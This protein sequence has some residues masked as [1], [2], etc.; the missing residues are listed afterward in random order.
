MTLNIPFNRPSKDLLNFTNDEIH[1][2]LNHSAG[3]GKFTK[4]AE[5]L[6]QNFH[7]GNS[8]LLTTSCTSALELTSILLNLNHGDEIIVPSFTF[9]STANA[10]ALRGIK[11]VFADVELGSLNLQ[12]DSVKSCLTEKTKAIVVVNYNGINEEIME[13]VDFANR[14]DLYLI[15][16]NA[17]GL[18]ATFKSKP[19]GTFGVLSTLSFH[20][21]KNIHCGEGGA[22]VINDD[23]FTERAEIIRDKGTNRKKFLEGAVDKYS[24][25]DLGSSW[26][27]S[28]ILACVLHRQLGNF[29]NITS[30]RLMIWDL[31][32]QELSS[33]ANLNSL[34]ISNPT[35]DSM[36][37]GHLF[38]IIFPD[39]GIRNRFIQHMKSHGVT[40]PFH[41]QGLHNSTFGKNLSDLETNCPNTEMLSKNLVRLPIYNDLSGLE[42][43]YVIEKILEFKF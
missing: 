31:Y 2:L 20:E 25:V 11:P 28:E 39:H 19:L 38:Y 4:K 8:V 3:N 17:H 42:A 29:K 23:K 12:I 37:T 41:Y 24:W 40:T 21:T 10:F 6:L 35:V 13:L 43:N 32:K 9:V 26:V 33:W 16:D 1:D 15:E 18:G 14:N 34:K 36:H 27:M 5:E 30:K 22:I 7:L